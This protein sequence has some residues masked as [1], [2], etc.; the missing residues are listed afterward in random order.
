[1][2]ST[3]EIIIWGTSDGISCC[4]FKMEEAIEILRVFTVPEEKLSV[5]GN[6]LYIFSVFLVIFIHDVK[7]EMFDE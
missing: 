5:L 4:V 1:M 3:L 7:R 2:A 6:I